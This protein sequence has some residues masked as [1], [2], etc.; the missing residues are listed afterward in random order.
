VAVRRILE[1]RNSLD[2]DCLDKLRAAV[3][4]ALKE[5]PRLDFH[6]RELLEFALCGVE[7]AIQFVE[8]RLEK[9]AH[10]SQH[11]GLDAPFEAFPYIE[12]VEAVPLQIS[13]PHDFAVIMDLLLTWFRRPGVWVG[14]G[15]EALLQTVAGLRNQDTGRLY[16]EDFVGACLESGETG[17]ACEAARFLPL[18]GRTPE[19][20]LAVAESAIQMGE[21]PRAEALLRHH[22]R[23]PRRVVYSSAEPSGPDG[24]LANRRDLFHSMYRG[25]TGGQLRSI[26][27]RCMD[28]LD[29]ELETLPD[30]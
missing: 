21:A 20:L 27:K 6:A 17:K 25:A 2:Q 3:L 15:V 10:L 12:N 16:L 29:A 14:L 7:S 30:H 5:A 19:L 26:I 18:E 23:P 11:S 4:E 1:H 28:Q 8:Y 9:A 24:L 13:S 22:M